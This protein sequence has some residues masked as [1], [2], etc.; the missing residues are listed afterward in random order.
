MLEYENANMADIRR[1]IAERRDRLPPRVPDDIPHGDMPGDKVRIDA[2]HIARANALFPILLDLLPP[3]LESNPYGR[4]V[5]AV[6]GGSGVGKSET[7]SLLTYYLNDMGLGAYTLSGDNYPHRIPKLNDAERLR[8]FRH[9]GIRGL[10]TGGQYSQQRAEQLKRLQ[11]AGE[12][13]DRA[14]V[15]D[16]PWLAVYQKEGRS[17]L[18]GYLGTE[19]E[20]DFREL[21]DI[22]CSFKNGVGSIWLK[23]MGREETEL[24][25]EKVD[26]RQ[27]RVLVIEWTHGNS[28]GYQGVDIPI[29]LNSTPQETLE[30]RRA[31][32]RDGAADSPFTTMV[33]E[34]EQELLA[35]QAS[36]AKIIM[37]K[38]GDIL[39]YSS[40]RLFMA[41]Q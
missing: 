15:A 16:Y 6:C 36:K 34:I 41:R 11:L 4:A 20:L 25:Y 29:F 23:R 39:D 40:Y 13:A 1:L 26:F 27:K 18:K 24:W 28:D 30:H 14:R 3:V 17:G 35:G 7:A 19:R 2:G 12:D 9:S 22:V 5:V 21:T 32:A 38:N 33:L 10:I 37:N 8:I 31:R